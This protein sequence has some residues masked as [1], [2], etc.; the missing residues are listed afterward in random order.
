[1]QTSLLAYHELLAEPE[2]LCRM[3]QEVYQAI[4]DLG[5]ANNLMISRHIHK[6]INSVTPRCKELREKQQITLSKIDNCPITGK[7]T[8]YWR[9]KCTR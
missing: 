9:I 1:M 7:K 8:K 2:K 3:Q 6:P 5:E 4:H